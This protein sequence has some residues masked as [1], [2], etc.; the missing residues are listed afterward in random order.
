MA[1]VGAEREGG[2]SDWVYAMG[3]IE[4]NMWKSDRE[5]CKVS[6]GRHE[7]VNDLIG[8]RPLSDTERRAIAES[9]HRLVRVRL[10][11]QS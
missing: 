4:E 3:A 1:R 8:T 2:V 5:N 10:G 9:M 11:G 7:V 6:M